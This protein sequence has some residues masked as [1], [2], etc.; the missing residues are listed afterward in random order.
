[1][2]RIIAP[3]SALMFLLVAM[4]THAQERLVR[5]AI[6]ELDN[7]ALDQGKLIAGKQLIGW[8]VSQTPRGAVLRIHYGGGAWNGWYLNYDHRGEDPR[9]GLVPEL[10]SGC[11]WSWSEGAP[12]ARR[13]W[14]FKIPCT[15]SAKNG[16]LQG[17]SL[18]LSS[19]RLGLGK[20]PEN[21]TRF[22]IYVDDENDGK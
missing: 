21:P 1:M 10:G 22:L 9:V 3:T 18:T 19:G 16:P 17:W 11:Y 5:R 14:G 4:M 12:G 13:E 20:S 7:V 6:L 2:E 8:Q 15:A